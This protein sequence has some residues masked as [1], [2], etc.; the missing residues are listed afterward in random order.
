MVLPQPDVRLFLRL[1]A[2]FVFALVLWYTGRGV[3]GIM[4]ARTGAKLLAA[5]SGM[6]AEEIVRTRNGEVFL[7]G[8]LVRES[9]QP[10]PFA[11]LSMNEVHWNSIVFLTLM[12]VLSWALVRRVWP[13]LVVAT[14]LL[15]LSQV[16]FFTVSAFWKVASDHAEYAEPILS[17]GAV[18]ALGSGCQIYSLVFDKVVPFLLFV[19][20]LIWSRR[21]PAVQGAVPPRGTDGEKIGRNARCPCGSG[22]KFKVCCGAI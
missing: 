22:K 20:V 8:G 13:W 6:P 7:D 21:A 14:G 12:F 5:G 18:S 11:K 17:A 10:F 3:Y 2:A 1:T 15:F 4:V 9:G 19:P 16:A